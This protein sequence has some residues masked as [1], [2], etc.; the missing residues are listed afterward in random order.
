MPF[1][2]VASYIEE[3][4]VID[5]EFT[6]KAI[7]LFEQTFPEAMYDYNIL[8]NRINFYTDAETD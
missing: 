1:T 8:M 7:K 3:G 2:M 4:K 5:K 6:D